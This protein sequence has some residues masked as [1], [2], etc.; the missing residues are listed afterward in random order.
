M[1]TLLRQ[2]LSSFRRS[3]RRGKTF[4][5]PYYGPEYMLISIPVMQ[6]SDFWIIGG[7]ITLL[8]IAP[9]LYHNGFELDDWH[10]DFEPL[11]LRLYSGFYDADEKER[12]CEYAAADVEYEAMRTKTSLLWSRHSPS[13]ERLSFL[14]QNVRKW[15]QEEAGIQ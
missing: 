13:G 1:A 11:R 12:Q 6:S 15:K 2:G 14:Q 8:T 5:L 7:W 10:R 4:R 9:V 3:T